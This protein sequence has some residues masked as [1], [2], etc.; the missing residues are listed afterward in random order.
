MKCHRECHAKRHHETSR[1]LAKTNE[2]GLQLGEEIV[3]FFANFGLH[4]NTRAASVL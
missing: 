4:A 3:F 1:L 2:K